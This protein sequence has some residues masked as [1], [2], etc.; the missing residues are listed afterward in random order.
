[1]LALLTLALAALPLALAQAPNASNPFCAFE[2]ERNTVSTTLICV[3][4]VIDSLLFAAFG[5]PTGSCPSFAHSPA[6]DDP[7]FAAY[8]NATC[9]GQR[10]CTLTSQGAD[11][12]NGVVK[13]I[14]AVATCSLA[15]GGYSPPGPP[16]PPT[17]VSPTCAKNGNPCPPPTWEPTW[18]LTQSTVIQPGGATYFMPSHPWGLISLDWSVAMNEWFKGNTENTTCEAT[19]IQGCRMLKAAGLANRCFI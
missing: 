3:N 5:T 18:N 13:S 6:C 2:T 1:M 8:A 11:P 16:P 14:A 12:C 15:P 9:L 4:G 19:S 17:P 7:T 10:T